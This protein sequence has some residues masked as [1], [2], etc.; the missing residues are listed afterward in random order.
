M[1]EL[2]VNDRACEVSHI[3]SYIK[4]TSELCVAVMWLIGLCL[5]DAFVCSSPHCFLYP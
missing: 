4:T 5:I 2:T 3:L 1:N